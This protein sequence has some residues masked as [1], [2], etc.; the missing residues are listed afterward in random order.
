MYPATSQVGQVVMNQKGGRPNMSSGEMRTTGAVV[1]FCVY[2]F[3]VSSVIHARLETAVNAILVQL[4]YEQLQWCQSVIVGL[5]GN[6]FLGCIQISV[7]NNSRL[8]ASKLTVVGCVLDLVGISLF[9]FSDSLEGQL[10][11]ERD[12]LVIVVIAVVVCT[13]YLLLTRA[14]DA[15]APG[16]NVLSN[17][18]FMTTVNWLLDLIQDTSAYLCDDGDVCDGG[19]RGV[20]APY[21]PGVGCRDHHGAVRPVRG[22]EVCGVLGA[23]WTLCADSHSGSRKSDLSRKEVF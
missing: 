6:V 9:V 18:L 12:N 21:A 15:L 22:E 5:L 23:H 7:G 20:P 17:A 10:E 13:V 14:F 4:V 3:G 16:I 11:S 19:F 8:L 2:V 1:V